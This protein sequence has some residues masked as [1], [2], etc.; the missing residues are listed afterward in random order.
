VYSPHAQNEMITPYNKREERQEIGTAFAL[1]KWMVNQNGDTVYNKTYPSA[2]LGLF[3]NAY[4]GW[5][6]FGGIG[7]TEFV[8]LPAQW[9]GSGVSGFILWAKPYLGF[10]YDGSIITARLNLSPFS[11]FFGFID[12]EWGEGGGPSTFTI[13]QSLYQSTILLHNRQPS[14]HTYWAGL[15]DSPGALGLVV[16]YEYSPN[17]LYFFRAEYSYLVPTPFS[18]LL[19]D[20]ELESIVGSVHY[21]TFGVFKQVK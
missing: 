2:S 11:L 10:Q 5:G 3:H 19:S 13:S 1:N 18:L 4:Y 14:D 15:R 20:E 7:G 9:W 16:G 21:I 8:C 6:N 12:G 17:K